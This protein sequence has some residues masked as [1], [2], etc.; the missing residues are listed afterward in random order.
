MKPPASIGRS[1]LLSPAT[2]SQWTSLTDTFLTL[3]P[4]LSPGRGSLKVSWG[5]SIDLLQL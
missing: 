5:V 3:K 1:F 2:L 4:T